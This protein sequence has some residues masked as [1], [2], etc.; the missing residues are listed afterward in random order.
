MTLNTNNKKNAKV[1]SEKWKGIGYEKGDSQRFWMSLL[2]DVYGVEHPAE[3]IRFEDRVKLDKT[4]FIDGFISKTH[5][6]IEQKSIDKDLRKAI[7]QSDG[8]LLTPFQQAKRYSSEIPY[9]ER[10]RW[11]ITCNFKEFHIY[12]MENP[13]G[14][15]EI[16]FLKDLDK[17]YYRLNFLVDKK[18]SNII[19][20]KE[21][22]LQAGEL[23][24]Q[25]YDSLLKEY[26]N[27]SDEET[28]KSLNI[29]CVRLVFCLYAEDAD[30]FGERGMF[31]DYLIKYKNTNFRGALIDL[32]KIL[33]E[34]PEERDPYLDDDLAAFP[35]VNGGLFQDKSV[36]IPRVNNE[37]IDIIL[38]KASLGFDWSNISP[39]IFG[40]VFESTLNPESRRSGGMH[41]TSIEN[42]HKVIN[43]LFLNNLNEEFGRIK[44][45]KVTK[46][47]KEQ[48]L[49]FQKKLSELK[50]LDPASG[51][52]NFL[53]ETYLS[54]RRL[55][56]EV[57]KIIIGDQIILG[58]AVNPIKVSIN[59][60]HGIEINDFAVTVA[61][62][63]LW[64][65]ESQMLNETN[66]IIHSNIDFL[67][68]TSNANIYEGNALQL[69]WNDIISSKELNYIMG[70]PP[71]IG[72]SRRTK[73]QS[74]DVRKVFAPYKVG[75]KLDYVAAWFKKASDY[76][77]E[78]QIEI[79][80]VSS[81]SICQGESVS[82]LWKLLF[83]EGNVINFAHETFQWT[84]EAKKAAAVMCVIVGFSQVNHKKKLLFLNN[85]QFKIVPHINGY[86]KPAPD[87]F[88]KNRSKAINNKT[89]KVVQGSPPADDK[90]LQFNSNEK[91]ILLAKHPELKPIILPFVGSKEFIND[92]SFVRYC[93][94]F[95]K[96]EPSDY[97]HIPELISRFSYIKSYRLKSSVDRIQ[98]SASK[99]YLFTQNRQPET[100]YLFIP[101]VSSSTRRYIPVG[102]LSKNIIASDSAVLVNEATI[103]DFSIIT[104]NV[105][106]AW[107]KVIAGRLKNDYR[108]A[109][110][111]FYNFPFPNLDDSMKDRLEQCGKEILEARAYYKSSSLADMYGDSMYLYPKL[112]AAHQNN[113]KAVME[114]YGFDW[115]NMSE[116][117]CIAEIMKL[118]KKLEANK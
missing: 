35:Y 88:I 10:P 86:L 41:Y 37:V 49:G 51:S 87:I 28:L 75:G 54:L 96:K 110:S 113:D 31:Y 73:G 115:R 9:S 98:K 102:F 16:I 107:V 97:A 69:N 72:Q 92:I 5:V 19:K 40:G 29:L 33:D 117:D 52:G 63:A 23:V 76:S 66:D 61:K 104:S 118:Y 7:K 55:E 67:P 21:V 44:S 46:K 68:L 89:N 27:P 70:N 32:F 38:N 47:R 109:P 2:Q 34:K 20:Q 74:E 85:N 116:T 77:K 114:S 91:D 3:Y 58:V 6:M 14:E 53:T 101:R 4:S 13:S 25:L 112:L 65:A 39:T 15:P 48:L 103:Y 45:I 22:S 108:Y 11:I 8:S 17:E 111:V 57:L 100:D 78:S 83:D 106:N 79:A 30:I 93:L 99:P 82:L 56:N 18:D 95:D 94:W 81:N 84:S 42:I 62:T 12:D 59:Q 50:F 24:G 36:I 105:H 43:P 71:F 1:F 60:F 26:K 80:F 90:K 64:I